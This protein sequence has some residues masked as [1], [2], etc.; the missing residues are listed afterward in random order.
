MLMTSPRTGIEYRVGAMK[1]NDVF[2]CGDS[3]VC[4]RLT[5]LIGLRPVFWV[6]AIFFAR[7]VSD[8][9]QVR[10][11]TVVIVAVHGVNST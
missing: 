10:T 4:K 6:K 5:L 11:R 2:A 3:G 8:V 1:V 9:E 7:T